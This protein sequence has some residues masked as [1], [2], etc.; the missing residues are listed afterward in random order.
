MTKKSH[1]NLQNSIWPLS[2]RIWSRVLQYIRRM[3]GGLEILYESKFYALSNGHIGFQIGPIMNELQPFF[4]NLQSEKITFFCPFFFFFQI[5]DTFYFK[6]VN[7]LYS[8]LKNYILPSITSK[9][10]AKI[11][12]SLVFT[13]IWKIKKMAKFRQNWPKS[14]KNTVFQTFFRYNFFVW[15]DRAIKLS[16]IKVNIITYK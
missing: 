10:N 6:Q 8:I 4:Q 12:F 2:S 1:I 7:K 15:N 5:L 13:A 14:T 9:Q 16:T 11:F 3:Y